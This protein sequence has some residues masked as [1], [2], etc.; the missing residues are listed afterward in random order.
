MVLNI[1]GR[2]TRTDGVLP[3]KSEK[4]LRHYVEQLKKVQFKDAEADETLILEIQIET[5]EYVLDE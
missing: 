4:E 1:N 3:L 5:L 2:V